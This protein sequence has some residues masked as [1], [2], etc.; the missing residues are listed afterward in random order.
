MKDIMKALVYTKSDGIHLTDVPTPKIET[1]TDVII[2]VDLSTICGTDIHIAN[3]LLPV[4]DGTIIGHEFVGTIA[5]VGS[6]V[7]KFKVGDNVNCQ[8]YH[9][10]WRMLLLQAWLHKSL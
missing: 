10:L 7:K 9:Y 6:A 3:G 1:N 8:L 5:E 2:R 4:E